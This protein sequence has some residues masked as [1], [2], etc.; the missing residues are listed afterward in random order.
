MERPNT[1]KGVFSPDE[2]EQITTT[3][4][5]PKCRDNF[6]TYLECPNAPDG[7]PS[8]QR[9]RPEAQ[10]LHELPDWVDELRAANNGACQEVVVAAQEL[11]GAVYDQVRTLSGKNS[12]P[13]EEMHKLGSQEVVT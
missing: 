6:T 5:F 9:G 13:L 1:F 11:G 12:C 2:S 7:Q 10:S 4:S 8:V 3:P